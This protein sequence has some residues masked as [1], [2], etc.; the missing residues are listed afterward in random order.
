[1]RWGWS[2]GVSQVGEGLTV[3]AHTAKLR[4]PPLLLHYPSSALATV[5]EVTVRDSAVLVDEP[6]LLPTRR[7]VEVRDEHVI[8]VE[9]EL[10]G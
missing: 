4:C 3:H 2:A 1:M 9:R 8:V 5:A 6:R 7:E 10:L